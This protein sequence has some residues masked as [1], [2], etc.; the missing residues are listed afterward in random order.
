[1]SDLRFY[2]FYDY[3]F[4]IFTRLKLTMGIIDVFHATPSK[5]DRFSRIAKSLVCNK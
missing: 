3:Q 4:I 2:Y 1:M 5:D